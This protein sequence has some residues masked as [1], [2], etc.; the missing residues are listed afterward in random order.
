MKSEEANL[1]TAYHEGGHTVVAYF[2][3]G[4]GLIDKVTIVPRG[5]SLGHVGIWFK[6]FNDFGKYFRERINDFGN[7]F[8]FQTSVV[9]ENDD[10]YITKAMCLAR[11]DIVL[12]GRAAEEL[13]FGA[14][15]ITA[16]ASDD[17]DVSL[18]IFY[19]L[20]ILEGRGNR[21]GGMEGV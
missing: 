1:L 5:E 7:N 11:M 14:N 18:I 19:F 3:E 21:S 4:V 6:F 17:L 8:F 15:K 2:S 16:N 13:V 10:R 9:P 20:L 12:G